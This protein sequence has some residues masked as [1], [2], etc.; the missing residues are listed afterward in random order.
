MNLTLHLERDV[1]GRVGR[2]NMYRIA[3]ASHRY[4]SQPVG[5]CGG[6]SGGF[7]PCGDY[8]YLS[9][10]SASNYHTQYETFLP[11]H[12]LVYGTY[13]TVHVRAVSARV[14]VPYIHD[15]HDIYGDGNTGTYRHPQPRPRPHLL[16]TTL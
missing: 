15:I 11:T 7:D 12:L 13:R 4:R 16:H 5:V 1:I 6:S 14:K 9:Y 2:Y 3:I 10:I 8:V